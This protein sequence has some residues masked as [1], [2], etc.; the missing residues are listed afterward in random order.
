MGVDVRRCDDDYVDGRMV[1]SLFV[2]KLI[3]PAEGATTQESLRQK[4]P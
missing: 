4:G 3:K 1:R 2:D